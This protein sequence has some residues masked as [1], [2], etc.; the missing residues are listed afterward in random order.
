MLI[1][2]LGEVE[3]EA[4]EIDREE[5]GGE[6][7]TSGKVEFAGKEKLAVETHTGL[8]IGGIVTIHLSTASISVEMCLHTI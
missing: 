4:V 5:E 2:S 1:V 3:L 7:S 6:E 8:H